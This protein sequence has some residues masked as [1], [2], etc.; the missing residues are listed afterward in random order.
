VHAGQAWNVG[1]LSC[2][3]SAGVQNPEW[4]IGRVEVN[5]AAHE[6]P[7]M[8]TYTGTSTVQMA[9]HYRVR[10]FVRTKRT[11]RTRTLRTPRLAPTSVLSSRWYVASEGLSFGR[12]AGQGTP[13]A[14]W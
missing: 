13:R 1:T 2:A 11:A 3:V 10:E 5:S 4:I 7:E 9:K 6:E 14:A 12:S 8:F